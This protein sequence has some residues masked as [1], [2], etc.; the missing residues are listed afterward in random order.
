MGEGR[1]G[2]ELMLPGDGLKDCKGD[3]K[4]EIR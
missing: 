3:K 2:K 1:R 4:E